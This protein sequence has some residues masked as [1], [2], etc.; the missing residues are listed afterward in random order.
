MIAPL[1]FS[2]VA[3]GLVFIAGRKDAARDPK[4]TVSLLILLAVIPM[5]AAAMP[6]ISILPAVSESARESAFP[7]GKVLATAWAVGFAISVMRLGVAAYCLQRW[8]NQA[9]EVDRIGGV[10]I[11][12]MP[13]L[14]GPVAAGIWSPVILV[15][16]SWKAWPDEHKRIVL[17]HELAHHRRRDPLW[18]LLAELACAVHWYHPLAHWM[19]RRFIMQCEYACDVRVLAK[20]IDPKTYANVLCDFASNGSPSPLA[21]AMAETGSLE[22]RVRRMLRPPGAHGGRTLALLALFGVLTACSLSMIGSETPLSA[23]I[24]AAEVELR[25]TANPFPAEP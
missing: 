17:E 10:A 7:W 20:G 19:K 15:P 18:R 11:C 4:L 9:L 23:D 14:Q 1:A 24:P 22:S 2:I 5:M 21:P 13:G 25:W 3:A 6:K 12:E 8:R 16:A